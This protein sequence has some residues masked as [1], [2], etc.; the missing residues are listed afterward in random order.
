MAINNTN[1]VNFLY[2]GPS[3]TAST[4]AGT[5]S[6][7]EDSRQI[8]VG[9]GT[10]AIAF[11]GNVKNATYVE[12]V[13]KISFNDGSDD[14]SLDFGDVASAKNVMAVFQEIYEKFDANDKAHAA[15]NTAVENI[16]K[17]D[18]GAIAVAVKA[19][20]EARE[21]ADTSINNKIGVVPD[22]STV[23]GMI[24]DAKAAAIAAGTIVAADSSFVTVEKSGDEGGTQTYT[25]KT[26]DIAKASDLAKTDASLLQE[27]SDRATAITDAVNALNSSVNDSDDAGF[28]SVSVT[29]AAGKLT[30][31][32]VTTNDIAKATDLTDVSTRVKTNADAI[33]TLNGDGAGSV[34]KQVSDAI[35][36]VVNSAP[37]AFDTLG[38]IA[39]WIA[40]DQTGA[41]AMSAQI[42]AHTTAIADNST[43]IANLDASYKA[44]DASIRSDFAAADA[45]VLKDAKDY[46]KT[47]VEQTHTHANKDLLDTYTQTEANLADAVAK[48]HSHDNKDV[49]DGISSAKVSA[50]DSAEQNAKNYA[51]GLAGNYATAAQGAKADSA[52]QS[53]TTG[54]NNGTI[55]VDGTDVAVKGLGSAAYTESSAYDAAG[56]GSAAAASA[57]TDAKA[58]S[59]AKTVNGKN[60]HAIVLTGADV[61]V[62]GQGTHAAKKVD[63]AIEELYTAVGVAQNAGVQSLAVAADSSK[64]ASVDNATGQVSISVK[65]VAIADSTE[66]NYGVAN[67]WDVKNYVDNAIQEAAMK[68]EVA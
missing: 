61:S 28:V 43:A 47:A 31:I 23:V 36:G 51:D 63:A 19:E 22:G 66:T 3:K 10:K 57:L 14:I 11:A 18:T 27:I 34:K 9:D 12:N 16:T 20:K 35:A 44:A 67:S 42:A 26:S 45:S 33:A 29:E 7:V 4:A 53:V 32:E 24:A 21:A 17:A 64:F 2:A 55:N 60:G 46:A 30:A 1:V 40:N 54:G 8:F 15:L 68:W 65:R 59:D 48:K 38:E 25:I 62:G 41:A 52:V 39:S 6:F 5:I 13:L 56:T 37:E 58:Y 50:W 49:L